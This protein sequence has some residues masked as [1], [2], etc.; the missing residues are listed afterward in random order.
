MLSPDLAALD[1]I[2][3]L[4]KGEHL[5]KLVTTVKG[6]AIDSNF[7]IAEDD[8]FKLTFTLQPAEQQK[9]IDLDYFFTRPFALA[10]MGMSIYITNGKVIRG[11]HELNE[12]SPCKY[13]IEVKSFKGD[14]DDSLWRQSFQKAYI[15]YRRDKINPYSSAVI[16]DLTT[17]DID[18]GF[19]NAVTFEIDK[20]EFLFYHETIDNIYGY[21][22]ISPKK[23][24][25]LDKL[26][27]IVKTVITAYGF[28][29]G[30]YV[31]DV[32]YYLCVKEVNGKRIPSFYF[33]N[34]KASILSNKPILDS[35]NYPDIPKEQRLLTSLQ[36]GALIKLLFHNEDYLRS[37]YL[38]IEA[39]TLTGC[40]KAS[41][42]AVALET[43]TKNIQKLN[44]SNEIIEDKNLRR[45][46][47]YKLQK[48]LKEYTNVLDKE[49]FRIL[50]NKINSLNNKPNSNKLT[51]AFDQ[52]SIRLNEDEQECINSRNRFLHGN[53]PQNKDLNLSDQELLNVLANR[54]AMLSSM[55]L[56]KSAGYN[57]YVIDRGM[58]EVIKWRMIMRGQKVNGGNCLRNIN[59]PVAFPN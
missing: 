2:K 46:L 50:T 39:G 9:G 13:E 20:K 18:D 42:G 45:N 24:I 56:L 48:V 57:G 5:Y 51:A 52:L 34:F 59:Q 15:K 47:I 4:E 54:L 17:R 7:R 33:E 37:A 3:L 19:Y 10:T 40:S 21:F 8:N 6:L 29:N 28:I 36:F 41:L 38:L 44:N 30:N 53:L 11:K 55:L 31:M 35:G 23:E 49:Q 1:L 25:D 14:V 32:V 16:F 27:A 12:D 58:T 43:I 22:V 26:Q